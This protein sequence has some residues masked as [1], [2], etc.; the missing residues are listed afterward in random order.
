MNDCRLCAEQAS[1][2]SIIEWR[3]AYPESTMQKLSRL[4]C[5][6]HSEVDLRFIKISKTGVGSCRKCHNISSHTAGVSNITWL[7]HEQWQKPRKFSENF[8]CM[9]RMER[10]WRPSGWVMIEMPC[11]T[12]QRPN[13]VQIWDVNQLVHSLYPM[14]LI[15]S[16]KIGMVKHAVT[17]MPKCHESKR[18]LE[19]AITLTTTIS[20]SWHR[21]VAGSNRGEIFPF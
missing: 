6:H 8:C 1:N 15:G 13:Y 20:Y 18:S 19:K 4:Q 9:E 16:A 17:T 5:S 10:D 11:R 21:Y 3:G 7:L 14:R 12:P 2:T